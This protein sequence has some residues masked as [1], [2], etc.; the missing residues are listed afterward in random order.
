MKQELEIEYIVLKGGW[1]RQISFGTNNANMAA[2]VKW[3]FE[4]VASCP[5]MN[6]NDKWNDPSTG[7]D[8]QFNLVSDPANPDVILNLR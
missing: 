8:R 6:V 1:I 5:R 7:D 4:T 2:M 3:D